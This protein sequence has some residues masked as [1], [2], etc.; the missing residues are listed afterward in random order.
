M[1]SLSH[2]LMAQHCVN[3]LKSKVLSRTQG[4]VPNVIARSHLDLPVV[5][6]LVYWEAEINYTVIFNIGTTIERVAQP[7]TE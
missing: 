7:A 2:S 1:A 3:S 5:Q 4:A 6:R